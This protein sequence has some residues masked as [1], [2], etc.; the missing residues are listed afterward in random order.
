MPNADFDHDALAAAARQFANLIA[1]Q[2]PRGVERIQITLCGRGPVDRLFAL[3]AALSTAWP[4]SFRQPPYDIVSNT[5]ELGVD[6]GLTLRA[7]DARGAEVLRC[8]YDVEPK[9][10]ATVH[11]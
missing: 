1:E 11:G 6:V 4:K 7:F 10:A 9:R 2:S 3:E 8:A 5:G